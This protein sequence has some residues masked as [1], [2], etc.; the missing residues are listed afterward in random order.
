MW[1]LRR[2]WQLR[3]DVCNR[4]QLV[5]SHI[6]N[7]EIIDSYLVEDRL[8]Q[9]EE[10]LLNVNVGLCTG[11]KKWNPVF[12][13]NLPTSPPQCNISIHRVS[14]KS[15]K[16]FRIISLKNVHFSGEV[17]C[18]DLICIIYSEFLYQRLLKLV[19]FWLTCLNRPI[20]NLPWLR[21]AIFHLH[22]FTFYIVFKPRV[23]SNSVMSLPQHNVNSQQR[24]DK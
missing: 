19:D 22:Y 16:L 2:D 24:S 11:L 14:Q 10:C 8:R 6:I 18:A 4:W 9:V 13:G 20:I 17:E 5:T 23:S 1:D 7:C 15:P 21:T 3:T 12:S